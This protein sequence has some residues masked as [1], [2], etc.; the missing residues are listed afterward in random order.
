MFDA[1]SFLNFLI[2]R[3]NLQRQISNPISIDEIRQ[4]IIVNV[5]KPITLEIFAT[6][7]FQSA[8]LSIVAHN[9]LSTEELLL[10]SCKSID[11]FKDHYL[12]SSEHRTKWTTAETVNTIL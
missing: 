10:F 8:A 9:L 1:G 12:S 7:D 5:D 4:S 3:A 6:K 2:V 11:E